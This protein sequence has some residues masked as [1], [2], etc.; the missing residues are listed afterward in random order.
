MNT[1]CSLEKF[2][3]EN[4]HMKILAVINFVIADIWQIFYGHEFFQF[5]LGAIS[6]VS[7]GQE[8]A[9]H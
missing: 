2:I 3:V 8:A 5:T 7:V 1:Y 4:L 9:T 6:P